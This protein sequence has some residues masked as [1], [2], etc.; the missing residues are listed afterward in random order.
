M[1]HN[2]ICTKFISHNNL[3]FSRV[4]EI[5]KTYNHFLW[6]ILN[7]LAQSIIFN[8]LQLVNRAFWTT[9][10]PFSPN[11]NSIWINFSV[12]PLYL[13]IFHCTSAMRNIVVNVRE[14]AWFINIWSSIRCTT[15]KFNDIV[16]NDIKPIPQYCSWYFKNLSTDL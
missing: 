2:N 11:T 9:V 6:P 5:I 14:N 15:Y 7:V 12:A 4:A 10:S 8:L 16:L 1:P 3:Y 13:G